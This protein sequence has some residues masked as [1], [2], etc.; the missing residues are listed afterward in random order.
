MIFPGKFT[1][2]GEGIPMRDCVGKCCD[3]PLCDVAFMFSDK[4]YAV[5]CY[6]ESLCQAVVAKPSSLEPKLAY[7]S[8]FRSNAINMP[9]IQSIMP[10]SGKFSIF[11]VICCYLRNMSHFNSEMRKNFRYVYDCMY[12]VAFNL[13]KH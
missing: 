2:L 9:S 3:T 4:C 13:F 10:N 11:E 7:V 1:E 12:S 6:D 5:G 8:K